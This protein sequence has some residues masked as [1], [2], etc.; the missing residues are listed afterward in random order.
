MTIIYSLVASGT[1]ILAEYTETKGNFQSIAKQIL[2]KIPGVN[3][4]VSYQHDNYVFHI[5]V[6]KGFTFLCMSDREFGNRIPFA[7]LEDIKNRF[8]SSYGEKARDA[9]PFSLNRDFK[10]VLQN[11]MAHFSNAKETDKI[12]IA[13]GKV[14]EVKDV[15]I[16]NIEKVLDRG[17][18]IDLLVHKTEDLSESAHNFRYK[19][20]KLKNTMWWRNFKLILLLVFIIVAILAVITWYLCGIPDF[21]NCRELFKKNK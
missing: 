18:K 5:M 11:Q 19:S 12:E 16:D 8:Q 21:R 13:K 7:F 2:E 1:N 15:M 14:A 3:T 17:E 9:A 6:D 10:R 20:K 4:K